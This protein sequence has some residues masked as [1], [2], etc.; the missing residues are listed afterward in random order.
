MENEKLLHNVIRLVLKLKRLQEAPSFKI[1][2][3]HSLSESLKESLQTFSEAC[4]QRKKVKREAGKFSTSRQFETIPLPSLSP[5]LFYISN[6]KRN[7]NKAFCL[8]LTTE[9]TVY[10]L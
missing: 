2:Y 8:E 10:I 6:T 7:V 5:L 3:F 4:G 1:F 9:F